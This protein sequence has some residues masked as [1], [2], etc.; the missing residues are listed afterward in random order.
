MEEMLFGFRTFDS[1]DEISLKDH[2]E[3]FK[4]KVSKYNEFLE[5]NDF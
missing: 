2:S 1:W 5:G 3:K 4:N